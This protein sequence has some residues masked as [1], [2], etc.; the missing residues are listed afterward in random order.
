LF[1]ES[2]MEFAD[3][4]SWCSNFLVIPY[5][6]Y[7][8]TRTL[9]HPDRKSAHSMTVAG[10]VLA[11]FGSWD[12]T[13]AK[14][15]QLRLFLLINKWRGYQGRDQ[16]TDIKHHH[17]YKNKWDSNYY[18]GEPYT[19]ATGI[20]FNYVPYTYMSFLQHA[21]FIYINCYCQHHIT[22]CG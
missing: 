7:G 9:E 13:C 19:T 22:E 4:R 15:C 18:I 5:V 10:G 16:S 11:F 2:I 6:L 20:F 21:I 17:V 14:L 3:L 12:G 1:Y 8:M